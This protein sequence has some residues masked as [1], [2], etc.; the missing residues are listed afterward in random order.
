MGMPIS[1]HVRSGADAPATATSV[2]AAFDTL[3]RTDRIFSPYRKDSQVNELNLGT[4]ALA[5]C[6]ALVREVLDLCEQACERTDGC[7][8]ALLPGPDGRVA[9]DPSG[10]VKGWAV[11][12]AGDLLTDRGVV[13]FSL[14]AG[15]DIVLR[16]GATRPKWRVGVEDPAAPRR[17][18]AVDTAVATSGTAAR[19]THIVD[20][21]SGRRIGGAVSVTVLGPSLTWA[22]VYATAAVVR[23]PEDLAWL[24]EHPGYEALAVSDAGD[25]IASRGLVAHLSAG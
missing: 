22:D 9:F 25:L 4:R 21:R 18:C 14:N 17:L 11:E 24:G 16:G 7:F 19:G 20:P 12:R 2:A 1:L 6:D 15:G 13:G 5:D 8:D 23:G 3:R 10:L